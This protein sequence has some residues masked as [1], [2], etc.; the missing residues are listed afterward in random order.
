MSKID[1]VRAEIRCT[2]TACI[3]DLREK[4]VPKVKHDSLSPLLLDLLIVQREHSRALCSHSTIA[5]QP[6]NMIRA[7]TGGLVLSRDESCSRG[8]QLQSVDPAK[9]HPSIDETQKAVS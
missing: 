7:P 2:V 6:I 8:Y 5:G 3:V 1:R 9:P 4:Q